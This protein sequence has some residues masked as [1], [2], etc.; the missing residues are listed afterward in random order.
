MVLS[1]DGWKTDS[2]RPLPAELCK[3]GTFSAPDVLCTIIHKK[4][5]PTYPRLVSSGESDA[6]AATVWVLKRSDRGSVRRYME[7]MTG[8][9]RAQTTRLITVYLPGTRG[10][11]RLAGGRG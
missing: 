9:S 7:K 10:G 3:Q 2:L 5:R 8:L 1:S 4:V 6:P 11:H